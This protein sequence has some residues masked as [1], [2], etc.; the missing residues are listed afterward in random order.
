MICTPK[1]WDAALGRLQQ[2][3]PEFAFK[4][5]IAPL[6]VKLAPNQITLGCPTSFHRDHVRIVYART[7]ER[8]LRESISSAS[9]RASDQ[10]A[11]AA[12]PQMPKA[13]SPVFEIV[14][15]SQFAEAPGHQIE[16]HAPQETGPVDGG[17]Q[18]SAGHPTG[19]ARMR[20]VEPRPAEAERA[21]GMAAGSAHA[22]VLS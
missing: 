1:V 9:S 12:Q 13:I 3:I 6:S 16:I 5:W 22:G 15:L 21:V 10:R 17:G 18:R 8:I 20:K 7:L 19:K 11:D 4:S 14:T 2:E